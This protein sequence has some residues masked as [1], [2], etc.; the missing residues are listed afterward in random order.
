MSKFCF[1]CQILFC[2]AY[3]IQKIEHHLKFHVPPP[4][5]PI[6]GRVIS[7]VTEKKKLLF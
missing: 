2:L 6:F 4:T 1:F 5:S 3:K 7:D